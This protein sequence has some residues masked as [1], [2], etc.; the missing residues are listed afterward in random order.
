MSELQKTES[1]YAA[2]FDDMAQ[3]AAW[4]LLE[5]FWIPRSDIVRYQSV[6]E[7]ETILRQFF[8]EKLGFR[9]IVHY[10]FVKLEKF[11][12]TQP[13]P[14]MGID[15][16]FEVRDYVMFCLLLA[17]LEGKS[18]D[19]QFLLS[20]IAEELKS[21]YPGPESVVWTNY[22]HRKSLVR[23]LQQ[24]KE[25]Y[26]LKMVDGDEQGF[27]MTESAE[28]LYEVTPLVKYFLRAYP[29][30]LTHFQSIDEV[31]QVS[32]PD[33]ET[34]ARRYRVYRQLLLSPV[35]REEELHDGDWL[36][37][38]NQRNVIARDFD[39]TL[40]L[41]LELYAKDAML[42]LH[43]KH[44]AA[45]IFP[46]SRAI[47]DVV[48]FFARTVREKTA[49]GTC[50]IQKDG[51]ILMTQVDYETLLHECKETYG[52]GWGKAIRD[53]S[54]KALSAQL[55]NELKLWGMA[56]EDGTDGLIVLMPS[57]GRIIARYPEDYEKKR[58]KGVNSQDGNE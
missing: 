26:L 1:K 13:A 54:P 19:D 15:S 47:S 5:R 25:W 22:E 7:R 45:T 24:A 6:R 17:Y 51:R 14:W 58:Q 35:V 18:I 33:N 52:H 49:D 27:A 37:L 12:N 9:L 44:Q 56:Q 57:L 46:D 41:S 50:T 11:L 20:E 28:V 29:K 42:V 39:E 38:R 21:T 55:L 4:E 43:E 10:E 23:V 8:Q 2:S 40:G 48:L 34:L 32:Q 30:D 16:F 53:M 31:L 36:Y 3:E